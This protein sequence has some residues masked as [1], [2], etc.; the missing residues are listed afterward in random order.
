MRQKIIA[1]ENSK[2]K[3]DKVA[4]SPKKSKLKEISAK[5]QSR[6]VK[7]AENSAKMLEVKMDKIG[8]KKSQLIKD[9]IVKNCK[10]GDVKAPT[11]KAIEDA[12]ED[13]DVIVSDAFKIMLDS[14]KGGKPTSKL[15]MK[16]RRRRK[17]A[18]SPV[19][20]KEDIRKWL[21]RN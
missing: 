13:G 3:R 20:N 12:T 18:E 9:V 6:M 19:G 8:P 10:I 15:P 5:M 2:V 11:D 17:Q 1:I 14:A 4:I 7:Y 21:E 16:Y